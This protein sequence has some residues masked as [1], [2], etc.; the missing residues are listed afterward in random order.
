M[1]ELSTILA[2]YQNAEATLGTPV[3]EGPMAPRLGRDLELG[4]GRM[5]RREL[6]CYGA[7]GVLFAALLGMLVTQT[8]RQPIA[9]AT[10]VGGMAWTLDYLRRLSRERDAMDLVLTLCRSADD[11]TIA[12][13]IARVQ[14]MM[15]GPS[16]GGRDRH[17]LTF[18]D[19][20][21]LHDAALVLHLD[22]SRTALFGGID[23][24]LTSAITTASNPSAQLLTD[25][26]ELNQLGAGADADVPLER[27][28]RNA[29]SLMGPRAERAIFELCLRK[30]DGAAV[31][32]SAE[33][34]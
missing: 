6:A 9:G 30:L 7:A 20:G 5:R 4:M 25:I 12:A 3:D 17:T 8:G 18:A 34:P 13:V 24:Q 19:V 29:L 21:R 10:L 26:H 23:P 1:N 22:R 28:L 14:P 2:R 31:T 16:R 27:W 15:R 11:P 33:Q 32:D